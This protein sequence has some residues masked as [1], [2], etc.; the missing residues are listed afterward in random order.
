MWF[1]KEIQ[2]SVILWIVL[3]DGHAIASL[4]DYITVLRSVGKGISLSQLIAALDHIT[5]HWL[6]FFSKQHHLMSS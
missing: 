4:T 2:N 3:F 1:L 6:K 5:S